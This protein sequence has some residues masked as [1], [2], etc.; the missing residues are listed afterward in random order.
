MAGKQKFC[1][2]ESPSSV[3]TEVVANDTAHV[4][5]CSDCN[6]PIEDTFE[7]FQYGSEDYYG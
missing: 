7:Y 2:C 4:D 1:E 5:Y 6:L 3:Y